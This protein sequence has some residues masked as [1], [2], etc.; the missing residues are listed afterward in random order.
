MTEPYWSDGLV[1]LYIAR[2]PRIP[3]DGSRRVLA[4]GRTRGGSALLQVSA[5]YGDLQATG[6][7]EAA[8]RTRRERAEEAAREAS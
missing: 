3:H 2:R 6:T 4:A 7:R 1:A 8:A 5:R